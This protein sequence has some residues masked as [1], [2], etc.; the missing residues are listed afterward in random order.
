ML[1]A[2]V[3]AAAGVLLFSFATR[4][5]ADGENSIGS[6]M[7]RAY[8]MFGFTSETLHRGRGVAETAL[9]RAGLEIGWRQCRTAPHPAQQD[10][11]L[12]S[13][14]P[15]EIIIRITRG[16]SPAWPAVLGDSVLEAHNG[17]GVLATVFA[18]RIAS[19]ASR[20][21]VGVHVLLG[22]AIAHE[23][24][25]LLTGTGRHSRRGL[26]RRQWSDA[27]L[28]SDREGDWLF[29]GAEALR[30]RTRLSMLRRNGRAIH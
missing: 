11:C 27:D 5:A 17:V 12:E 30:M 8:D 18:D 23:V 7:L 24:G 19:T 1:K 6:V 25:H 14:R 15:N 2:A 22:R 26:M 29:S 4:A 28:R 9:K 3:T 21:G 10:A 20:T 16:P 13:L